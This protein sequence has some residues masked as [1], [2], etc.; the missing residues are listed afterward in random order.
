MTNGPQDAWRPTVSSV[1]YNASANTYTLSGTQIS[2][3]VNGADEGD[4]MT[5]AQNYPIVW[6][7]DSSGNVSYC[8][9]FN[10]SSMF[11]SKG[12]KV[13]TTD[14][15]TPAGLPNGSYNLYVS[16]VG[17]QSKN[18]FPFTVG[19]SSTTG[20]AGSS[21]SGTGGSAAG[22]GG[23]AGSAA[24]AGNRWRD[25]RRR[26]QRNGRHGHHRKRRHGWT[27]RRHG[28][29]GDHDRRRRRPVDR[30]RQWR[31][32]HQHHRLGW[33]ERLRRVHHQR[34]RR[35]ER[36]RRNPAP[37]AA[38]AR[39][40]PAAPAAAAAA[41]ADMSPG[42]QPAGIGILGLLLGATLMRRRR[43]AQ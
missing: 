30:R 11:P 16:A 9:S 43:R 7:T 29:L 3:L 33:C 1:A 32:R 8:R 22:T 17:V 26:R 41:R 42:G 35:H 13:E 19:Q 38:A 5:M 39:R 10:F 40:R 12:S 36:L 2:G 24:R 6:L 27:R 37:P 18:P 34:Q 14:F 28:R 21:G 15:T 20:A 25:R 23:A 31:R 4:D